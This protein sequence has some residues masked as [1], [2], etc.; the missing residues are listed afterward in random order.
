MVSLNDLSKEETDASD[1]D[2]LLKRLWREKP[3]KDNLFN[4]TLKLSQ[5]RGRTE[6]PSTFYEGFLP[7]NSCGGVGGK[8][9]F[10][11]SMWELC[12]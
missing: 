10:S 1:C 5:R 12:I 9:G 3:V 4:L 8:F 6:G 11:S 7:E 2:A